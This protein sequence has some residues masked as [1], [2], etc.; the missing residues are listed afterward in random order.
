[1]NCLI[2]A[3][4]WAIGLGFALLY[5]ANSRAG[6]KSPPA[7]PDKASSAGLGTTYEQI[8]TISIK[9][10]ERSIS[11]QTICVTEKGEL[12]ALVAPPKGFSSPQKDVASEIRL[13]S[14]EGKELKTWTVKFHANSINVAPDGTVYVA[15]DGKVARFDRDGKELAKVELPHI[16]KLLENKA[17][18]KKQAEEQLKAQKDSY[19]RMIKIY[20]G[21]KKKIA[22]KKP[23][24][25]TKLEQRQLE[26]YDQ[27]LKSFTDSNS[28]YKSLTV[29]SIVEQITSRLRIINAIAISEKDVFIVCGES[30]GY[31]FAIWR[32][33]HDFGEAKQIMSNVIGCCGQMD[34]QCCGNDI[35]VAENTKHRFAKYDR[36]GKELGA[37]GKTGKETE[38]GCF[39]G[40]CNP[41]NLRCSAS[42]DIF[43]AESEGI[44][45]HFSAK[46]DSL[47]I[48]G[49]TKL[50][51]G[52]KCVA[53]SVAPEGDKLYLCDVPNSRIVVFGL[54]NSKKTESGEK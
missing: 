45:K 43:T 54:K 31:G 14:S 38:P 33:N 26:Q 48:A 2:R 28:Y 21:M 30:Q 25:R 39:G 6:E 46:G 41:M 34:V 27:I 8:S 44:I 9:G 17:A 49:T 51:G 52:C 50:T 10:Q 7:A 15:G 22:D 5:G 20:E 36:D 37:W 53:V 18:M 35:L 16:A 24:D 29:E 13:L 11:L 32:M 19:E 4:F 47:G 12:I 1:M 23:E 40:C 3:R 42:G